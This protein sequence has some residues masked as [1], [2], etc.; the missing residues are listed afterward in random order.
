MLAG[1]G[2]HV[3]QLVNQ[4]AAESAAHQ[5]IGISKIVARHDRPHR[6]G[7]LVACYFAEWLDCTVGSVGERQRAELVIDMWDRFDLAGALEPIAA[8]GTGSVQSAEP[9]AWRGL[10]RFLQARRCVRLTGNP[11]P[12]LDQTGAFERSG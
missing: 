2:E 1:S 10:H 3:D 8:S 12:L 9:S 6:G 4:D 7:Y 11:R 5:Q